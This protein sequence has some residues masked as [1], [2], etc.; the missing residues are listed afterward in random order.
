MTT[1]PHPPKLWRPILGVILVEK[2][3]LKKGMELFGEKA[4]TAVVKELTQIH[5]IETYERIMY[6]DLPWE[7]KKGLGVPT[8]Y[9]RKEKQRYKGE[10]NIRS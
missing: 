4:D 10:E 9:H 8:I 5:E 1:R 2:Y 7:E 3:G 6:S